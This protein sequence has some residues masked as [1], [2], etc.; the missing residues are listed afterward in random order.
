MPVADGTIID[1]FP[2]PSPHPNILLYTV[3]YMVDGLKVKGLLAEPKGEEVLE[4]F[5]YLRGG[6][7]NVGKVR[8]GR[9]IQFAA[10]GFIVFAPFY[11]G[12]QGGEGYDDFV[13]ENRHDAYAA[14]SLLE[15]HSRVK[16]VHVFGFSRGGLMAL[17]TA[18]SC[19]NVASLVTWGGVSDATLTYEERVDMRRMLKRVVGGSPSKYPERYD[20]RTPLFHIERITCPVLIIH[21]VKDQNVSIKHA[22]KLEKKLLH[23]KK[24]VE[25]WYFHEYSHYFPPKINRQTVVN[26]TY[27]MKTFSE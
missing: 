24:E 19:Y 6:I 5:L 20:E 1:C 3:T 8:P 10:Q 11:R 18:I 2:F 26:L 9:I 16:R 12:N 15:N 27:W 17:W 21:G 25:C 14:F 7:N 4:G 13:G 22:E 23:Y